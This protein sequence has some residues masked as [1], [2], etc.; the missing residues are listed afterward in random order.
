MNREELELKAQKY[1][2][3]LTKLAEESLIETGTAKELISQIQEF[4]QR[5]QIEDCE[6]VM[7]GCWDSTWSVLQTE[8]PKSDEELLAEIKAI[9]VAEEIALE[10]AKKKFLEAQ[11][12][13]KQKR[14]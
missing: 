10:K 2:I 14:C 11:E 9:D 5:H 8:V 12:K 7:G 6:V 3:T 4:L 1:K 13:I